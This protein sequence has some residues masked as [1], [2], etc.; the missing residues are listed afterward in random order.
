MSIH[1]SNAF[2]YSDMCLFSSIHPHSFHLLYLDF[3]FFH[4]LQSTPG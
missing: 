3:C 2:V 1:T 4:I